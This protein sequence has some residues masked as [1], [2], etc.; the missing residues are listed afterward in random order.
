MTRRYRD[1]Y[2]ECDG[3]A[4]LSKKFAMCCCHVFKKKAKAIELPFCT[5]ESR[6]KKKK[7][8]VLTSTC[9]GLTNLPLATKGL[10][11]CSTIELIRGS[12]AGRLCGGN[13]I[14]YIVCQRFYLT[15]RLETVRTR[16]GHLGWDATLRLSMLTFILKLS[17]IYCSDIIDWD[18]QN[19][20]C[21]AFPYDRDAT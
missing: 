2:S 9:I 1:K 19:L 13:F 20:Q 14:K 11:I 7:E 5:K 18:L 6:K 3:I 16:N 17:M 21:A 15:S 10:I 8:I 4:G 12:C